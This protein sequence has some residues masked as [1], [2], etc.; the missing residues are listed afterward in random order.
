MPFKSKAKEAEWRMAY[1]ERNKDKLR[2]Q[3]KLWEEKN[4]E[5]MLEYYR[6]RRLREKE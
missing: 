6:N 1:R 4:R 5:K 3:R 2:A